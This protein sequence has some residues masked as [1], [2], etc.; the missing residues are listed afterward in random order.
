[1]IDDKKPQYKRAITNVVDRNQQSTK[2]L[3]M[4]IEVI[5]D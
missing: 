4:I 2:I 3:L 5:E 1:M